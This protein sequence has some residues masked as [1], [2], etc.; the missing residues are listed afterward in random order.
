MIRSVV[1]LFIFAVVLCGY[2][3]LRP[4]DN[5]RP[6]PAI[7]NDATVTRAQTDIALALVTATAMLTNAAVIQAPQRNT[8]PEINVP[9]DNST[10]NATTTNVLAGL[11]LM[12][13]R[14]QTQ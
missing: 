1:A 5:G 13:N 14:I 7:G 3:V 11:G 2:I 12:L 8:T 4:S 10:M 6:M 9:V